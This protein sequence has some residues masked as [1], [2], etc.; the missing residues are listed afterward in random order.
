MNNLYYILLITIICIILQQNTNNNQS[1]LQCIII[2]LLIL[3]LWNSTKISEKFK[4]RHVP[5]D[6]Y[7][8][9]EITDDEL[10][11]AYKKDDNDFD[12]NNLKKTIST[13]KYFEP[14]EEKEEEL[15]CPENLKKFTHLQDDFIFCSENGRFGKNNHTCSL[16][17]LYR[18][19]YPLCET[20]PCP[21][22]YR[23]TRPKIGGLCVNEDT[24]EKCKLD[25]NIPTN[26]DMCYGRADYNKIE[27]YD[28]DSDRI[29]DSDNNS[30]PEFCEN[31][32]TTSPLCSFFTFK[33][34]NC[35]LYNSIDSDESI[36][37]NADSFISFKNPF[38]YRYE[39]DVVINTNTISEHTAKSV[40][41]CSFLCNKN[42]KC[43]SFVFGK[44][45][46]LGE[47]ILKNSKSDL[48]K[49]YNNDYDLYSKK[50]N[51]KDNIGLLC[52]NPTK[53]IKDEID[54]SIKNLD[55]KY[56][57][58]I[59]LLNEKNKTYKN[60]IVEKTHSDVNNR[61]INQFIIADNLM[62]WDNINLYSDKIKITLLRKLFK[63]DVSNIQIIGI[64]IA[65]NKLINLTTLP[66]I[67]ISA[68]SGNL[69]LISKCIDNNLKT[70]FNTDLEK[71]PN[72]IIN[73]PM[74]YKIYK[75]IV[76]GNIKN[77]ANTLFP[78]KIELQHQD[79]LLKYAIKKSIN[80]P[81]ILSPSPPKLPDTT[82]TYK[83]R[84][85]TDL[86]DP[87]HLRGWVNVSK[88]KKNFDYC[89]VVTDD[90]TKK[91]YYSCAVTTNPDQYAYNSKFDINLGVPRTQYFKD[92]SGNGR[93]DFCRCIP[94]KG[95]ICTEGLE[96]SFGDEFYPPNKPKLC[97]GYSGV[98]LA[99]INY[100]NTTNK[101]LCNQIPEYI[102]E[103]KYNV[104]TGFY[105]YKKNSYYLFKNS[106]FNNKKV[107]LMSVFNRITHNMRIGYPKILTKQIWPELPLD[108]YE[109]FDSIMYVGNNSIII[110]KDTKCI[111]YHLIRLIPYYIDYAN[112]KFIYNPTNI[113]SIS[114]VFPRIPFNSVTE[115]VN[116]D[117]NTKSN[118]DRINVFE[119]LIQSDVQTIEKY[120][121]L[122]IAN[123]KVFYN[124]IK[125]KVI[126]QNDIN[127][128]NKQKIVRFY[129]KNL[130]MLH[131]DKKI[132]IILLKKLK[133]ILCDVKNVNK[134]LE[135]F[136]KLIMNNYIPKCYIFHNDKFVEY[137]LDTNNII[138]VSIHNI[139][140]KTI[141]DYSYSEVDAMISFYDSKD[142]DTIIFIKNKYFKYLQTDNISQYF[143]IKQ[144]YKNIWDINVINLKSENNKIYCINVNKIKKLMLSENDTNSWEIEIKI[145]KKNNDSEKLLNNIQLTH[146]S[147]KNNNK[148]I[149]LHD[150]DISSNKTYIHYNTQ[151]NPK[152]I[153]RLFINNNLVAVYDEF[154]KKFNMDIILDQH[155]NIPLKL[156]NED[157]W[158]DIFNTTKSPDQSPELF[159]TT[160][161]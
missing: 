140:K 131:D 121:N 33:K 143:L 48:L 47:C 119:K 56:N 152:I 72:I 129:E 7:K 21:E 139:N 158:K 65:T 46:H 24:N 32:C 118:N 114:T 111:F 109:G 110:F 126:E 105:N 34:N 144:K 150:L 95:V 153:F 94:D 122:N 113:P 6:L 84:N 16:N 14:P 18:K 91:K 49:D 2:Y 101:K 29:I 41:D 123:K 100:K 145:F 66:K 23:L 42:E 30:T 40:K 142:S 79:I 151:N 12:I 28:I 5:K 104:T 98:D 99:N 8:R 160:I 60:N 108:F 36:K 161:N 115:A 69:N 106:I 54:N 102:N 80:T 146:N 148:I 112:N 58:N 124:L 45:E 27:N 87:N 67:K 136:Y 154:L 117:S 96:N 133:K 44:N 75:I 149:T 1:I 4:K 31:K 22:D 39:D 55:S 135:D 127:H 35:K 62:I 88:N 137:S 134:L 120:K 155:E 38:N 92:E 57:D 147:K 71:N 125:D 15:K 26:D 59:I 70:S 25:A 20:Y 89:R 116:I 77:N 86:G 53:K 107:V 82:F 97:Q 3:I 9:V 37:N 76:Y 156:I 19:K 159:I 81:L 130:N 13:R 51:Y 73:L 61:V 43:R 90:N 11:D 138:D 10:L 64:D 68:S 63:L 85:I 157:E 103:T 128:I 132:A 83:S 74:K 93:D 141:K 52:K 78:L 50:Y 17:P